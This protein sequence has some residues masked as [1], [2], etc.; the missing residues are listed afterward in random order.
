MK[1]AIIISVS[2]VAALCALV[3]IVLGIELIAFL[4]K[5]PVVTPREGVSVSVGSSLGINE[6]AVIEKATQAYIRP[7]AENIFHKVTVSEDGQ[8]VFF[9][10]MAG[11]YEVIV[12][13]R[14][15]NSELRSEIVLVRVI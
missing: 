4:E 6:L 10:G 1:K 9:G 11:D 5:T 2:V 14:G 15:A 7:T 8:S 3:A 12:E 13:A